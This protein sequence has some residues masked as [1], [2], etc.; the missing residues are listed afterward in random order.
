MKIGIILYVIFNIIGFTLG[1]SCYSER[2]D[3]WCDYKPSKI[4]YVFPG[5]RLG[6]YMQKPFENK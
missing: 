5:F 3:S 1:T 6:C 4:G 2:I